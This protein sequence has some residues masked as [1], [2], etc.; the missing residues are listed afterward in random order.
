MALAKVKVTNVIKHIATKF[1]TN[2]ARII[3]L[4]L[5]CPDPNTMAFGG[6][7]TG[8][9]NAQLAAIAAGT[10]QT[11]GEPVIDSATG[12]SKGKKPAAVAVLLVIS[13][14]NVINAATTNTLSTSPIA[15]A[16]ANRLAM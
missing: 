1:N 11:K 13:V 12:P 7:A 6:V 9:I 14:K 8:I 5:I 16:P 4:I 3:S 15:S 10:T 2:P